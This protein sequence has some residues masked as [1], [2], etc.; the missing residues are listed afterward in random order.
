MIGQIDWRL[1]RRSRVVLCFFGQIICTDIDDGQGG[2]KNR[3]AIISS[4]S[5]CESEPQFRVIVIT[6]RIEAPFFGQ[7]FF[8]PNREATHGVEWC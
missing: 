3:P 6:K 8:R 7:R 4:D 2:V 5:E 1:E